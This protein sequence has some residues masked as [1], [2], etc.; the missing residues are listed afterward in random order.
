[1]Y[2][3]AVFLCSWNTCTLEAVYMTVLT[4]ERGILGIFELEWQ[5]IEIKNK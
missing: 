5:F 4:I 2:L 3:T 1:M